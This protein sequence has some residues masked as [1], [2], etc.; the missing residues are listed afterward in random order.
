ME[1]EPVIGL[2]VHAQL[3][4][5]SKIFCGCSTKFGGEPNTHTCPVCMGMP[6]VLPVLNKKVVDFAMRMALA[7]DCAINRESRFARKNYFYPDLP[8]GYQISQYELPIA[9]H[10][11]VD[12]TVSGKESRIGIT[13][14]HMEEDAGKL[15]HD[16]AL[17]KSRV[18][19]NRT[20]VPL[21]EIVSEPEIESPPQAGAY[22]KK[23]RDILRYLDI[24]DGNM[25]EGSFRCDANVSVRPRGQK[26]LGTR[27][28]LK[29]MNSFKYVEKA[30]AF[31]ITRQIAVIEDG[32][33]VV[34]ESRLFD[35]SSG[36][37][38]S[39]RGKE[40]A[41]DYRYFP[42]PDL[43]PLRIDED[44]INQTKEILPELP[45][46][47]KTRFC[48]QYALS[49]E[50]ADVLVQDRDLADYFEACVKDYP[51]PKK[52]WNWI[53]GSLLAL[54][55]AEG[56]AVSQS[57]V[58]HKNLAGLLVM[59]DKGEISGRIA[60]SMFKGMASSGKTPEEIVKEKGFSQV[61]DQG[62]LEVHVDDVLGANPDEVAAYKGGKKKLMGFFVGQIMKKTKGQANPKLVNELLRKK[63]DG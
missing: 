28:E 44:W 61:S 7:T 26:E 1:F 55:N 10:G 63:L 45:G 20:G 27:T 5:K 42:D 12:V 11:F 15:I 32:G 57:P 58:S 18:D 14:I 37:T 49:R 41:H 17:R 13:R 46:P 3:K 53:T 38:H 9:E 16:A 21:I 39:M 19:L 56:K 31:E 52:A 36:R 51:Q 35:T 8:K 25:E 47:K 23:I 34:Q 40:E 50:E 33:A 60:K 29:N 24:C 2:E 22:L 62:A 43:L 54:L 59:I 6:G 48:Q 4:T 30:L